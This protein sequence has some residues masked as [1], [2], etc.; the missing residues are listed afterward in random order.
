MLAA[1]YTTLRNNLKEYCDRVYDENEILIITRK[2][3]RN[4]VMMSMEQYS[5]I[6]KYMRNLQYLAMLRESEQQLQEGRVII[7]TMDELEA[8]AADE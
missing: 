2:A 6:E 3:E 8:M 5:R 7:K 4:V 1:N